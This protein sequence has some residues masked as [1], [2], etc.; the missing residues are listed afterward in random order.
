MG[1]EVSMHKVYSWLKSANR[2]LRVLSGR[3]SWWEERYLDELIVM[4][5]SHQKRKRKT[6]LQ[7]ICEQDFYYAEAS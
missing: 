5:M 1:R 3:F 7:R 6:S 2:I 4:C